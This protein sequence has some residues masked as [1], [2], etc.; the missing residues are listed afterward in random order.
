MMAN[1]ALGSNPAA[2]APGRESS[3]GLGMHFDMSA[4]HNKP[5]VSKPTTC[6]LTTAVCAN[7]TACLLVP[8]VCRLQQ[9]TC[10]E[11]AP[12]HAVSQATASAGPSRHHLETIAS[13]LVEEFP[14]VFVLAKRLLTPAYNSGM[15]AEGPEPLGQDL[16]VPV[17]HFQVGKHSC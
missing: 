7:T 14:D 17:A 5:S 4:A 10:M 2:N 12:L 3:A 6:V 1:T 9:C 16:V 15:A 13:Q 8:F 11:G